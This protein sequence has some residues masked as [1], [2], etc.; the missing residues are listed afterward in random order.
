MNLSRKL[1]GYFSS[2]VRARGQE[3]YWQGRVRVGY[4]SADS[5]DAQVRGSRVYNVKLDWERGVL[6]GRCDCAYFET[7]GAC[8][9]LWAALLASE[10]RG[11]L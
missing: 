2:A 6:S 7:D 9:H 11:F 8:K 5:V 10:A 1:S 4:G 3:Y